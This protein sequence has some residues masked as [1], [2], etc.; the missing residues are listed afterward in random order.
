MVI[1]NSQ[2]KL[3]LRTRINRSFG[4]LS[5]L[6]TVQLEILD[7]VFNFKEFILL[8]GFY[9]CDFVREAIVTVFGRR[10]LVSH[11]IPIMALPLL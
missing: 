10:Q 6:R 7:K 4:E 2:N 9:N 11:H 8:L 1:G 5:V 3:P